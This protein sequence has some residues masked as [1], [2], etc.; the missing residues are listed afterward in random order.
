MRR[1]YNLQGGRYATLL[2]NKVSFKKSYQNE[3]IYILTKRTHSVVTRSGLSS[4]LPIKS[5]IPL[6]SVFG[7]LLF[8]ICI[9]D[10]MGNGQGF[11]Q[12][13]PRI[14]GQSKLRRTLRHC[15]E[16]WTRCQIAEGGGFNIQRGKI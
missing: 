12:M 7:P 3:T 13:K 5:G 2:Q 16:T 15:I 6:G 1:I 9:N 8:I 11:P 14:I 10:L 4:W